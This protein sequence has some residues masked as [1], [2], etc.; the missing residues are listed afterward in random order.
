[1]RTQNNL[2]ALIDKRQAEA[3]AE[4]AQAQAA[5]QRKQER[6]ARRLARIQ[7]FHLGVGSRVATLTSQYAMRLRDAAEI[8]WDGHLTRYQI[9]YRRKAGAGKHGTAWLLFSLDDDGNNVTWRSSIDRPT[10][11]SSPLQDVSNQTLE[12]L[13]KEFLVAALED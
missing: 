8:I 5:R 3:Q 4:Q 7:Q 1:M 11:A 13:I 12:S 2:Q 9:D 10:M 6:Q